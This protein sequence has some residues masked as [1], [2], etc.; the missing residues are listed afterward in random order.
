MKEQLS[1]IVDPL[2][3]IR[4]AF[5]MMGIRVTKGYDEIRRGRLKP[6]RNGTRTFIRASELR[7]YID[8]LD[9]EVRHDR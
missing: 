4:E 5:A 2:V 8:A 1:S 7:R 9:G 3:P 6:V